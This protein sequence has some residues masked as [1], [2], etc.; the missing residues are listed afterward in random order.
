MGATMN[1]YSLIIVGIALAILIGCM[2]NGYNKGFSSMLLSAVSLIAALAAVLL[3]A[4]M[5]RENGGSTG[6]LTGILLLIV[7]RVIYRIIKALLKSLHMFSRLPVLRWA[8]SLLG[9]VLGLFE[10]FAYLYLIEYVLRY[11]VLV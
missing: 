5:V 3:I 11:Y 1:L 4:G 8:D 9:L 10:G 7:L 2:T 6:V